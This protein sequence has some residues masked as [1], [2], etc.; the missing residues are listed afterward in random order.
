M[1]NNQITLSQ[2]EISAHEKT[3]DTS[4]NR[5]FIDLYLHEID[6]AKERADSN[7]SRKDLFSFLR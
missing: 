7:F 2:K 1:Y 3:R 5:D 6:E 4:F